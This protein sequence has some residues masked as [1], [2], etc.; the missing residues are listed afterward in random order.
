MDDSSRNQTPTH[1]LESVSIAFQLRYH[2][3]FPTYRRQ[4]KF[5]SLIVEPTIEHL[6][7]VVTKN[8]YHLLEYS[9]HPQVLR[10]LVSLRPEQTPEGFTRTIKGNLTA[11]LRPL[12]VHN[13]WSRGIF[14]RS[15]GTVDDQTITNYLAK[16]AEHHLAIPDRLPD[17]MKPCSFTS[18]SDSSTLQ[19]ASHSVYQNNLHFVFSVTRRQA[20]LDPVVSEFLIAYWKRVCSTKGWIAW[21]ISV[22]LD[23]AHLMVGVPLGASPAEVALSLMNNSE[24]EFAKRYHGYFKEYAIDQLWTSGFYVGTVGAATTDQIAGYLRNLPPS[25]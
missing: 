15:N 17:Y 24:Y 5:T 7:Q 12:G 4:A 16:Q 21:S 11:S 14:V 2:F 1:R 23:H 19:N 13:L 3:G 9:F 22:V 8:Q 18:S 20:I 6:Q 10:C 25:E